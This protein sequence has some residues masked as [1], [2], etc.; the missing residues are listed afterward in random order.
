MKA[1]NTY[2]VLPLNTED[3]STTM[4]KVQVGVPNDLAN[5]HEPTLGDDGVIGTVAT[6]NLF[7]KQKS[8]NN[9]LIPVVDDVAIKESIPKLEAD[10][11]VYNNFYFGVPSSHANT[12]RFKILKDALGVDE[13]VVSLMNNVPDQSGTVYI[14]NDFAHD[15]Y[16]ELAINAPAQVAEDTEDSVFELTARSKTGQ[17]SLPLFFLTKRIYGHTIK[18]NFP[19]KRRSR[20][21]LSR[22]PRSPNP[23]RSPLSAM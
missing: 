20:P 13:P 14:N 2:Q 18:R 1:T 8:N 22:S 5:P 4:V 6:Y 16:V 19:P 11:H 23:G 9:K 12:V 21:P 15:T 7:I 10:G 3:A 17:K